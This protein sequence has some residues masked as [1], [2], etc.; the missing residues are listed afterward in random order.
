MC[1]LPAYSI[2]TIYI[3]KMSEY[4]YN[5]YIRTFFIHNSNYSKISL[6]LL[7]FCPEKSEI[8]LCICLGPI[9]KTNVCNLFVK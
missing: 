7:N 8:Y 5:M 4:M 9:F 3:H 1:Y 6:Y 2:G